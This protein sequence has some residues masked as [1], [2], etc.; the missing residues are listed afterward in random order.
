MSNKLMGA[1]SAQVEASFP[2]VGIGASAGGLKVLQTLFDNLPPDL[3]AAYVVIVHLDPEHQSELAAILAAHTKM[4]VSQVVRK[5]PLE[6]NKVYVI[7]PNRRL[8]VTDHDIATFAFDEPRG[9]RAPID[10]FFR[11]LADQHGDGFAIVLSGAGS[12]GTVGVKAI[13]EGGGIILVQDPAEAEYSSMP[14]SAVATGL[15]DFVLP[16]K[17]IAGQLTE[18]IRAKKHIPPRDLADDDEEIFRRIIAHLRLRTGHDFSLYKRSTV[19]RRLARRMQ[20]CRADSLEDYYAL[21]RGNAEEAQSL[22]AD[23]LISV[24]MFFRDPQAFE[25]LAWDVIPEILATATIDN[26][27]RVWIPGCA[28]GEEA[29]SIGMLF[30]EEAARRDIRPAVQIFATD[31]DVGAL[32]IAREGRYPAAITTDISDERLRQFFNKEGDHY[33]VKRELRDIVLFASHSLLKDPPFSKLDL[34]SCRNLLIYL[35]RELQQ[36]VCTTFSYALKPEGFLFL[37][38]SESAE[39]PAGLFRTINREARIYQS[40]A[41]PGERPKF[42]PRLATS[43]RLFEVPAAS[44]HPVAPQ[45]NQLLIH[46]RVL[47]Q[48]GPPSILVDNAY[49]VLHISETAGRYLQPSAGQLSTD[50]TELARPELRFDLRICLHKAFEKN[51]SNLSLPIPVQFNGRPVRVYL[52][53]RAAPPGPEGSQRAIIFFIEG[54]EFADIAAIGAAAEKPSADQH[55]RSLQEEL[56]L[57]RSRLRTSHEEFE[58]ANE[59]LRAANEE[60]QSI[61]E[62]YRS[63]AEELE[64]SKEEL[65]SIN[66]E[67][68]TVNSELKLKLESV[69]RVNSDLQNLMSATDVGILFLDPHLGIKRFTPPVS[70]LFNITANDEGRPIT[71]FTHHLD[72]PSFVGDVR[73]VLRDLVPVER[74]VAGNRRWFLARIKPYRTVDDRIDGVVVTFVD[75]TRRLRAEEDLRQGADRTR[76]LMQELSHRVKNTLAVVQSMARMSLKEEIPRSEA[77]EA[78]TGRLTALSHAHEMLVDNEWKGAELTALVQRQL[79][80]HLSSN[81]VTLS[82]PKVNLPPSQATPFALILHELATNAM[83]YGALAVPE[84]TL[85][86]SWSLGEGRKPLLDFTWRESGVVIAEEPKRAGFGSYLIERGLPGADVKRTFGAGGVLCTIKLPIEHRDTAQPS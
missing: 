78:F 69:S 75:I 63:T 52:L 33:R 16:A 56:E 38:S 74:E 25:T 62:E 32:A 72:Y 54:S 36:Q 30:I 21:L 17:E 76:L 22:F 20:V 44:P 27:I 31:L 13:K 77:L 60:L 26:P 11:S 8:L 15:A 34:I 82:G 19:F 24:T 35:D 81:K 12:D 65:Q 49:H 64:T 37:G 51:A 14:R 40:T 9:H 84:G 18:L 43:P 1:D 23:L 7:P 45:P 55:V 79:G 50:V 86:L 2:T 5:V 61:N 66:E 59:E 42:P 29:Y 85:A 39:Q 53:V 48:L 46:T 68:Q 67:L 4:P 47:E 73:S 10:Q 3:G 6:P 70:N 83:K 71:D 58:A 57:T 80:P 41:R 28:T